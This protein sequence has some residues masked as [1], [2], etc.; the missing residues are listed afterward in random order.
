M[1]GSFKAGPGHS[2]A[3]KNSSDS[4]RRLRWIVLVLLLAAGVILVGTETIQVCMDQA[5]VVDQSL[6]VVP[7]CRGL[8][9]TDG[10]MVIGGILILLLLLPDIQEAGAFG[11]SIK[12][13]VAEQAKKQES[14]EQRLEL[15]ALRVDSTAT[16]S[17]TAAIH[18]NTLV[19]SDQVLQA[20]KSVERKARIFREPI[21]GIHRMLL[22]EEPDLAE[23]RTEAL[24]RQELIRLWEKLEAA[25]GTLPPGPAQRFMTLFADEL[26]AVR[27]VRNAVAHAR[28]VD[29]TTVEA[30]LETA[31]QLLRVTEQPVPDE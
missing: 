13:R 29:E 25:V 10:V 27:A 21:E 18:A 9:A 19:L 12:R 20:P 3:D 14:L 2:D 24:T 11:F 22:V 26:N 6:E 15:I 17:A 7:T 28:Q 16:A 30:S 23:G 31:R 4:V 8:A 1:R 5:F